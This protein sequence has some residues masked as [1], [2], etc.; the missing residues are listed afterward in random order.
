MQPPEKPIPDGVDARRALLARKLLNRQTAG[1][2]HP[3]SPIQQ[4]L[5][6]LS[7]LEPDS[8]AYHVPVAYR[9]DGPLDTAALAQSLGLMVQRHAVLRTTFGVEAG[10]PYQAIGPAWPVSLPVIDLPTPADLEAAL[11]EACRLP[12]ELARG[13]LLR[14]RLFRLEA[15]VHV[16]LVVFHHLVTDAWSVGLFARELFACYD[17]VLQDCPLP[18]TDL[19]LQYVDVARMQQEVLQEGP[20]PAEAAYWREHLAGVSTKGALPTD[21]PRPAIRKGEGR[22]QHFA[23][24]EAL[25]DTLRKLGHQQEATP[26]MV[27]LTAF[28]VLLSQWSGQTDLVLAVPHAG[29]RRVAW[30]G[31]IGCFVNTLPIRITL[32]GHPSFRQLLDRVRRRCL[33]AFDHA[34]L[35]FDQVVQALQLARDGGRIPLVQAGFAFQNVPR[36]RIESD[37][38]AL[39]PMPLTWASAPFD[40]SLYTWEHP[41]GLTGAWEYDTAVFEGATVEALHTRFLALL[42]D[43]AMHPDRPLSIQPQQPSIQPQQPSIQP[44]QPEVNLTL[45]QRLVWLGQQLHPHLPLYNTATTFTIEGAVDP[46]VFSWAFQ[47]VLDGCDALRTVIEV[48]DGMPQQRVLPPYPYAME[49]VDLRDAPDPET[50]CR[51]WVQARMASP[52]GKQ[53]FDT[54]LIRLRA[55]RTVWF[56]CQHVLIGDAFSF[57]LILHHLNAA[58]KLACAGTLDGP[59][60]LPPFATYLD[61]EQAYRGSERFE[62]VKAY[63][64]RKLA[65]PGEPVQF[66]DRVPPQ[67]HPHT[68]RISVSLGHRRTQQLADLATHLGGMFN[69]ARYSVAG[70]LLAAYTHRMTGVRR[71]AFGSPFHN[72]AARRFRET[73][74]PFMEVLV[75]HTTVG[76]ED[77]FAD[78]MARIQQDV[79][80]SLRHTPYAVP[81]PHTHR[82][83]DIFL[84]FNPHTFPTTFGEHTAAFEQHANGYGV[85]SL[86]VHLHDYAASGSLQIDLDFHEAVFTPEERTRA[87]Q[88]MLTLLDALLDDPNQPIGDAPL[89]SPQERHHLLVEIN[90]TETAFPVEEDVPA[91]LD[92]W[93]ALQPE[94]PAVVTDQGVLT[95]GQLVRRANQL[96]HHL[97]AL[98]VGPGVRVGVCLERSP[99]LVVAL[100]GILKAGGAYVPMD[101]AYPAERLAFMLADSRAA[102]LLT[103]TRWK[104]QLSAY[105]GPCLFL[106]EHP[107]PVDAAP[108]TPLVNPAGP[109]DL[110]YVVYT[111]GST[112]KPK[113]VA[114]LRRGLVNLIC[115]HRTTFGLSPADRA[116]LLAAV[117]FDA[118]AWEL[119]SNLSSGVCLHLPP[120]DLLLAPERLRDWLVE[121]AITIAFLPTPL[122]ERVL[123]LPWP[124]DTAL[125]FLL[126]GGDQ[127]HAAPPPGLPFTVVNNYGPTENTVVATS[128]VITPGSPTVPD[129]GRP[130]ANVQAYVV[131]E[132][133]H[134]VPPG[135]AGEL[136]LG[137]AGLEHG[138]L[139][140]PDL[141]DERFVPNPFPN[142]AGRRF[143]RTGD[144]VR[145]RPDGT[146][147]FLG[148]LDEQVKVRGYRIEPGEIAAVLTEHPAVQQAVVVPWKPETADLCLVAYW[149]P[150][151]LPGTPI[152]TG[153]ALRRFLAQKLPDFM[154]PAHF[155]AC[156]ALPLTPQGKVDR[157]ALPAPLSEGVPPAHEDAYEAPWSG[158]EQQL[159]A[160]I[161]KSLGL[162]SVGRHDNFF[163]RGGHSL[164][165]TRVIAEIRHR[166]H[167]ELPLRAIFESPTV[168]ALASRIA[169]QQRHRTHTSGSATWRSLVPIQTT[170]T[171]PPLFLIPPAAK[172]PYGFTPLAHRLGHHQPCYGLQPLGLD[173]GEVPHRNLPA[174]AAHYLAEIRTLQPHGPYYLAGKCFGGTVAYE[175][176]QQLLAQG[177][178]VAL[179]AMFDVRRVP[180]TA[181]LER[182]RPPKRSAWHRLR[183]LAHRLRHGKL[184]AALARRLHTQF[185][186]ARDRWTR[187]FGKPED[188]RILRTFQAN[189]EA[190]IAY[191]ARPYPGHIVL[192]QVTGQPTFEAEWR[193]ICEQGCTVHLVPGT[194]VDLLQEPNVGEL[195]EKLRPYLIPTEP[196]LS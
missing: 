173:P 169:E 51:A 190:R 2:R 122:A 192:F 133:L 118:S 67:D 154:V 156:P 32:D 106:D 93:A 137:G 74:G 48:V 37:T 164:L 21:H 105:N 75:I 120:A 91:C 8:V 12:F 19:P 145:Y 94:H 97:Q 34:T 35:P 53:L 71:L 131:D 100:L 126:T 172:T 150:T 171:N 22:R 189:I 38:L 46:E 168:A 177:E 1:Q 72:R 141:T 125:R 103:H 139:N 174:M 29:R 83:Y 176:A 194:H 41:T 6:F 80:E 27:L 183:R 7:Q 123:P 129:I 135:V 151:T 113:G 146:L 95:F 33:D 86:A 30:E 102:L 5:W 128:G 40:L 82:A 181:P 180:H 44:Q 132:G 187:S 84:N 23:F 85:D 25:S 160:L 134:L 142:G 31:L 28:T 143:Y 36:R 109:D 73:I 26:F 193:A 49:Q 62:T 161:G 108:I 64:Q 69:L 11:Q 63:W 92:K 76:P 124:T 155:V 166:F 52:L 10:H 99:D 89:L 114:I 182:N 77:T 70:A 14:A 179:L 104:A 148:R 79:I 178:E 47:A 18:L 130:I 54:A 39:H 119:W 110:A 147:E 159:A 140:R 158:V 50:A 107:N 90:Q 60:K 165:A 3:L 87:V 20:P 98:G 24:P 88:H 116:T 127:L 101:P 78:L 59:L 66:F 16:L 43:L 157:R 138:Y 111:S 153:T 191:I 163:D 149:V 96:A 121:T 196:P 186:K 81:N 170:G 175:M 115:W 65:E 4:R 167:V 162:P 136:C 58:Y 185:R 112:G 9:L 68:H 144:R 55:D 117:A 184:G 56:F 57:A 42:Q 195:A 15:Q 61:Y 13:P 152:P 45:H 17:A 188:Q